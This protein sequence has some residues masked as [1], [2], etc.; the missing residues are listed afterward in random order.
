MKILLKSKLFAW[1][2]R[3][4]LF[5]LNTTLQ[6]VIVIEVQ[7]VSSISTMILS[8]TYFFKVSLLDLYGYS[9]KWFYLIPD[10]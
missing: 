9:P 3:R 2:F 7:M 6:S 10:T 5:L 4:G 1:H 8:N